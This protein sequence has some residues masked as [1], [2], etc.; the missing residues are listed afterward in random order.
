M[1]SKPLSFT[2][3]LCLVSICLTAGAADPSYVFVTS[4]LHNG[5]LGGLEGADAICNQLAAGNLPGTYTAWLSV[6]LGSIAAWER[7]YDNPDGYRLADGSPVAA[8]LVDMCAC[9]DV[10]CLINAI[11]QTETGAPAPTNTN[12]GFATAWTGTWINNDQC[13]IS[14]DD[15]TGWLVSSVGDG[16]VG[17][18]NSKNLFWTEGSWDTWSDQPCSGQYSLYCFQNE[19]PFF[20]DGFE[21]GNT[22][23]WSRT[24]P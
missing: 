11:N 21:S 18:P 8:Q 23:E 2:L 7:V 3:A 17:D 24:V 4:T 6:D 9:S 12:I 20:S 19:A 10:D 13:V 5:N 22:G 14:P 15:C 1:R 16:R